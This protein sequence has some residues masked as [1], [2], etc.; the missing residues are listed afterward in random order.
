M[1]LAVDAV[2]TDQDRLGSVVVLG[3]A[4][5]VTHVWV[6]LARQAEAGVLGC[7]AQPVPAAPGVHRDT[8][9]GY[10]QRLGDTDDDPGVEAQLVA[11]DRSVLGH[12]VG[13]LQVC[14]VG[15]AALQ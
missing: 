14:T 6:Q 9:Q 15:D 5:L 10:R 11:G 8:D 3:E 7:L 12:R 4:Q 2:A 1:Y 13:V